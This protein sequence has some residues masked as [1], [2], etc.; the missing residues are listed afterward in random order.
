MNKDM[1]ALMVSVKRFLWRYH[2]TIFIVIAAAI[3]VVAILS[4]INV[5]AQSSDIKNYAPSEVIGFDQVTIEKVKKLND[6]T[7]SSFTLPTNQR[8]NP[9]T[10]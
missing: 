1:G 8:I 9:F 5:V 10:E 3:I 6:N 2:F 4:L 7:S